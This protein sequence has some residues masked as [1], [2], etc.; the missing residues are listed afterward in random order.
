MFGVM[1]QLLIEWLD[2]NGRGAASR[3]SEASGLS[4]SY[5]SEL[6]NGKGG[7]RLTL[8]TAK[9]LER[10]TGIRAQVWLGLEPPHPLRRAS[11]RRKAGAQ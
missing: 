4:K 9:A 3:L 6:R 1:K 7:E 10:G 5:I 2:K 8:D 11:D